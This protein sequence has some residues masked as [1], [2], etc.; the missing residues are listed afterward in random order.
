[1]KAVRLV[2]VHHPLQLQ[3]IP[4]PT[5][6]DSDVLVR[7]RAAGI[8]HTDVHY[9]EGTSPVGPLPKTPGHEVAGIVEQVGKQ[10]TTVKVGERVCIHYVLSCGTCSY[11]IKGQEQ[12]CVQ[13]SMVGRYADGGYAQYVA[14]PASN[15]VHLPDE[16]PFEQGAILMCSSATAF[17]ALRKAKLEGGETVAIF[18]IGGLGISAVQLAYAFGA[19]D[20]Y[21][22]DINADK[23]QLAAKYGA[24]PLNASSSDP[25]AEIRR[26]TQG[27]GVDVALEMIGLPL[28]MKQAVQSLAVMGRAVVTGISNRPLEIDTYADLL[29]REAIVTGTSDHLLLELPPLLELARRGKLDLSEVVTRTIPLEADAINQ[30]MDN[31][32]QFHSDVRTVIVP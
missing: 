18:G 6:G 9:R 21:A 14:V 3:E 20:V 32:A 24:I 7:V 16:I 19:L 4:I 5:I 27:Q 25:V 22:V 26:R 17:H 30:V 1:M 11:C 12:F 23:L 28:T 15:V 29:G 31:L 13:G 8:C 2:E 10:V